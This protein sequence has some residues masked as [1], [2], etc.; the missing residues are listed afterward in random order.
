MPLGESGGRIC[1]N[2][3][4]FFSTFLCYITTFKA[5]KGYFIIVVKC[6]ILADQY[7]GVNG[8]FAGYIKFNTIYFVFVYILCIKTLTVFYMF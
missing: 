1:L 6:Y 8:V 3:Y 5:T 2:I 4:H 7:M